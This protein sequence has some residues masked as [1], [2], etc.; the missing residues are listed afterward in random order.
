M[1]QLESIPDNR[2]KEAKLQDI[3]SLEN[4][5]Q[6]GNEGFVSSLILKNYFNSSYFIRKN[7]IRYSLQLVLDN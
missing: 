1:Q 5:N 7:S 6:L 3:I 4:F 2:L